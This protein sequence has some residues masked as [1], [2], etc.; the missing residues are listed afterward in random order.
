MKKWLEGGIINIWTDG[1]VN[2]TQSVIKIG[3]S[4]RNHQS[5]TEVEEKVM[6]RRVGCGASG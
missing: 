2:L 6:V 1:Q 3:W 5:E 4:H